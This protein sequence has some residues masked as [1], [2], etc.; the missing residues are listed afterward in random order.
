MDDKDNRNEPNLKEV[1]EKLAKLI[2]ARNND[3]AVQDLNSSMAK[4]FIAPL[5]QPRH[6]TLRGKLLA[7]SMGIDVSIS[8][9]EW[10]Q[11]EELGFVEP[12]KAE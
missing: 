1:I 9:E 7:Y 10:K 5:M 12:I 3:E 8:E 2:E 6:Y 4:A 11:A